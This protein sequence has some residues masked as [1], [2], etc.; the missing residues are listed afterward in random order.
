[1]PERPFFLTGASGYVGGRLLAALRDRGASI[2]ALT[3]DASRLEADGAETVVGDVLDTDGLREAL[4]GTGVAYYL[5][6]SL[7]TADFGTSDRDAARSFASA[8]EAAGIERI[9]YLGGLGHGELSPHLASRQEVGRIL[10]ESRVPT[11]ELRA[12]VVIGDGSVS[13][14]A[15][16][17]LAALP[18]AVLPDWIETPSQPIAVADVVAYLLEAAEIDLPASVVYEIGGADVVPYRAIIESLGGTIATVP[19][20]AAVAAVATATKPLQPERGRVVSDL[21]DSLRIDTSVHD[22]SAATAFS[23]RPRGL[24]AA[25]ADARPAA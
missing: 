17:A 24:A 4:A 3:R 16:R 14:D 20:P 7:G 2:R 5:V 23:V 15:F 18:L 22:R 21:L 12:S 10:R 11:V 6:H 13:H 25:V 8:A 19:A 1:M 9:V